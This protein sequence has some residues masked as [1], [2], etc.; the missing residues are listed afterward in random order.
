MIDE[1]WGISDWCR[2]HPWVV[3]QAK[4][5]APVNHGAGRAAD[6]M[7]Q[8]P[9]FSQRLPRL[10]LLSMLTDKVTL[11]QFLAFDVDP[12]I[13]IWFFPPL[14]S[15][16]GGTSSPNAN[17]APLYCRAKSGACGDASRFKIAWTLGCSSWSRLI[18][19]IGDSSGWWCGDPLAESRFRPPRNVKPARP[20]STSPR[21]EARLHSPSC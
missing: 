7:R 4:L 21:P 14:L 1:R 5:P 10:D 8:A 11:T 3:L 6:A 16:S 18:G 9:S 17:A 12:M 19:L 15:T 2:G 13:F 20:S